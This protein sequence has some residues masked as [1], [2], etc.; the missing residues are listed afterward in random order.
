MREYHIDTY[1]TLLE[2]ISGDDIKNRGGNLSV[3]QNKDK[4]PLMMIGQD[5]CTFHQFVFSKWQLKGCEGH[6]ILL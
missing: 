2:N 1:P 5:E 6:N 4:N 3:R